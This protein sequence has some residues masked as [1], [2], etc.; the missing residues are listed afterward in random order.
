MATAK[1]KSTYKTREQIAEELREARKALREATDLIEQLRNV[2]E[3]LVSAKTVPENVA[4]QQG[5]IDWA[6]YSVPIM[7]LMQGVTELYYG[8]GDNKIYVGRFDRAGDRL[9]IS[10]PDLQRVINTNPFRT[11]F[12]ELGIIILDNKVIKKLNYDKYYTGINFDEN[13]LDGIFDLAPN[14]LEK[15]LF[16]FPRT[17]QYAAIVYC[18]DGISNGDVRCANQAIQHVF[19]KLLRSLTGGGTGRQKIETI[20]ELA[21]RRNDDENYDENNDQ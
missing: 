6:N 17:L 8:V 4:K 3:A 10:F 21:K 7:Q 2:N 13:G 14:E 1:K 5:D 9:T 12:Q 18:M 20:Y 19:N 11:Y 16:S 15:K